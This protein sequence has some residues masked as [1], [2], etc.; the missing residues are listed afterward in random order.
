MTISVTHTTHARGAALAV[1]STALVATNYVTAKVA[2]SGLNL[3]TF[4]FLWFGAASLLSV[5][6]QLFNIRLQ[7]FTQLGQHWRALVP[8][9]AL[10][11]V[12]NLLFFAGVGVL[13]PAVSAICYRTE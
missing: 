8:M 11:A 3:E 1:V 10:G 5:G 9:A 2:L 6:H 4:F 12:S 13:D 7:F